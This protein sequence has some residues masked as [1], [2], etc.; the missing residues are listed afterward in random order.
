MRL[1]SLLFLLVTSF[2]FFSSCQKEARFDPNNPAQNQEP[3]PTTT[4]DANGTL[5]AKIDGGQWIANKAAGAARIQGLISIGGISNDKRFIAITLT[6]SGVHRYTLSDDDLN[7][8][9]L[10]DSNESDPI[11]YSTNQG[12]Y[13]E[14]AGGEVN[15]TSIDAGRQTMS[16]TFSFKVF[17]EQDGKG[18]TITEGSFTNLHYITELPPTAAADTFRVKIDGVS[19][20]PYN[21][22]GL[23]VPLLNQIA[24][25]ATDATASK[26]VGLT[27]PANITPGDYAFDI[28]GA[29]YVGLYNP[30]IDPNHSKASVSGTLTILE[31]NT[32]THRIRG[33]FTFKGEEIVNPQNGADLTEGYFSVVY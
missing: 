12:D 29:T 33:N 27:F 18:K 22:I 10:I 30:N 24:V 15:V 21:I 4:P 6:D 26:T 5:K 11:N 32:A 31:H 13:P 1:I 9:A 16:G 2:L 23:P 3:P 7:A 14:Q 8:A 17:R 28:L 20:T 19:W 25:N